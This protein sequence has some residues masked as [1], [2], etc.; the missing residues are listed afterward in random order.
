MPGPRPNADTRC[1]RVGLHPMED[2]V[3][4]TIIDVFSY[5]EEEQEDFPYLKDYMRKITPVRTQVLATE[6]GRRRYMLAGLY[7]TYRMCLYWDRVMS[8]SSTQD[9][10]Y[11]YYYCDFRLSTYKQLSGQEIESNC[12]YLSALGLLPLWKCVFWFALFYPDVFLV[13]FV[14]EALPL[15]QRWIPYRRHGI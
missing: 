15:W 3:T 5:S 6:E 2:D 1:Q 11:P 8:T 9:S 10:T 13:R 12:A 14:K 4:E 7:L